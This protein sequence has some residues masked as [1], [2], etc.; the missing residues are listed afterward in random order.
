[1]RFFQIF[2]TIV[3][4]T[5]MWIS[6]IQARTIRPSKWPRDEHIKNQQQQ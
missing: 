6:V 4:F 1:M 5:N 2:F 3:V